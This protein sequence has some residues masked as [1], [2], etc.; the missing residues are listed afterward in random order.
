MP[1][2][3]HQLLYADIEL[4]GRLW[5]LLAQELHL[6]GQ[7]RQPLAQ[8]VVQLARDPPRFLFLSMQEPPGQSSKRD[9][10]DTEILFCSLTVHHLDEERHDQRRLQGEERRSA[11]DLPPI[12]IP[13][14]RL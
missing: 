3:T 12:Q 14:A 6:H 11:D 13:Q 5:R 7:E 4:G 9:L 2:L 1:D 10:A 8:V